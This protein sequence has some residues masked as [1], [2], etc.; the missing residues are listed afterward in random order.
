M[1]FRPVSPLESPILLHLSHPLALL[2]FSSALAQM[3]QFRGYLGSLSARGE[4]AQIARDVLID[5]VDNSGIDFG[6][7]VLLLSECLEG[8]QLLDSKSTHFSSSMS[9]MMLREL[10]P[11]E[12]EFQRG[13]ALCQPTPT[14]HSHLMKVIDKL[15][16]STILNKSSL[17]IKPFD[18]V[19]G[20]G[21]LSVAHKK[22]HDKDVVSKQI[23]IGV[24][25]VTC[26]HCAGR[27]DVGRD[28][29]HEG[30]PPSRWHVWEKI[31]VLHCVCGGPWTSNVNLSSA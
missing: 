3:N 25:N 2:Q 9:S 13:L 8:C 19:D 15:T 7:L 11:S 26:L 4:N 21:R 12:D 30:K 20:V 14:M 24:P 5:L 18:L 22:D 1:F 31:W 10:P 17:F 6:A 28:P 16:H 27:S 29:G 23:L